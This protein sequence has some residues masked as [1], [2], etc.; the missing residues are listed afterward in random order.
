MENLKYSEILKQNIFLARENEG[1]NP[2][3]INILSNITCNQ[4]KHILEFNLRKS[5]LNPEIKVGHYDNIIQDSYNC[6]EAQLVL[7]IHDLVNVINKYSD[8]IE[9]FPEDKIYSLYQMI[10]SEIDLVLSNLKL[11][12]AI[13][14]NTFASG[15]VYFNAIIP[16]KSDLLARKL[17]EY[18]YSK[19]ETNLYVLDINATLAKVGLSNSFDFRL[20]YTS[21]NLYTISFWKEY[22]YELSSVVYKFTGKLKKAIIFDCDNTLWKGIL[23]EDGISGIDM[24]A[25]SKTGQI[26]NKIQQIAIWLSNQGVIV[27]LCS[28]NNSEDVEKVLREHVDMKLTNEHIVISEINW[29]DKASNF[30]EIAKKLNIGLDSV[31][32]VDDSSFEINLIKEQIPEILTFQV[33]SAINEYPSQLLRLVERHF[34]LSGSTDDIDKK[35]QY[36]TQSQRNEEMSKYQSLEDYLSSIEIEI[37]IKENDAS[38]VS[39]ISQLTQK[40][41]QFNLTTQRYTENQIEVFM[42]SGN[43]RIFSISVKDKFGES[44][45]TAVCI[46]KENTDIVSIDS[47]LMSCRIMGRNI[48]QAIMDYI[49]DTYK[50]KGYRVIEALYSSSIKNKPASKFYEECGFCI[51]N[52]DE[53]TKYYK[54]IISDYKRHNV[55]YIKIKK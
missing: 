30:R 53:G 47:F 54:L 1:I 29:Q 18:L 6:K 5:K 45:L 2:Y 9:D 19:K 20:F 39:R 46:V 42:N 12:P 21:K 14:Y 13:V 28:K 8:F 49:V 55:G 37:V 22:V 34:Y 51:V 23:G 16:S 35:N 24:S 40:T 7:V 48:E 52:Q 3:R 43:V 27:G 33:P 38:Q 36:K 11:V 4:L 17:N 25:Q 10:I 41:N 15:G 44:G 31:V 50:L 32:F 26:Y